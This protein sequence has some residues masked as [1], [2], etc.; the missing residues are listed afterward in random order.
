MMR[1]ILLLLLLCNAAL[2]QQTDSVHMFAYFRQNGEDGLHLAYSRDGYTWSALKGDSSFLK[3]TAG[4]DKLMRD[5]CIIRGADGKFHM[6]WTVS[7]NEQSIGYASSED[8][9]HWSPQ[10]DIPVMAHEPGAR[11]CWAP[12]VTYD[13]AKKEYMIYWATTIPGRFKEGDTA[14][15]DKYNHRMYY[16]TTK[17][18]STFSKTRLL[19]D[20]KFNVIDASIQRNGKQ[21]VMFLKDETKTPPQ[22]NIRIATAGKLTGPYTKPSVP[23]TGNYWAEGPTALKIKDTWIVYFD[24]YTQ[25]KYGAVTSADLENWTDVSDRL[26]MP[27]GIRHG[28]AFT[29]SA[30]EFNRLAGLT[31]YTAAPDLSWTKRVGAKS[32]PAAQ[33]IFTANDYGAVSDTTTMNTAFIQKAIDDCAAKG[34]GIVTLKPGTYVTGSLFIKSNVNFRIDDGVTLLGSQ[35]FK[36]YPEIDTRIAGIEMKWPAAMINMLNVKN[37]ALTGTGTINGRGRFCWDKYW[38]MRKEDYEPRGLRWIVDYDAKR[39]RTV[40]VQHSEDITLKGITIKNAGFWTVQLL[41]STRIT[42]DGLVIRNNEDGKGPSTDGID[43]DS[44]TWVLIENCDIDCNDDDFCLKAGRDWDGLRVNRPTEYVVIRKCIARRGGG[45]LTLGSETSGGIRHVLAGRP[46][47]KRHGQR[48]P[49]QISHHPR[50]YRG[51]HSLPQYH[52]G[53]CGQC[54]PLYHELEPFLQLFP[55]AG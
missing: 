26:V 15:D 10:K 3:P 8:L 31:G 42:A 20:H 27:D 39:V 13:P 40:L 46:H 34:G 22:K 33:K 54:L 19:Y 30:A 7:W 53:Q 4:K 25:H 17:D 24:K 28:T 43:V 12:E 51:R 48:L 55:F 18:F 45:L 23:I 52:A 50:R 44:S 47:R 38:K 11:N 21:Y 2:A 1:K 5:P 49:H 36:D 16:V 32:F 35:D 14:G 41:Y 29:I 9:V 6:V 37:A